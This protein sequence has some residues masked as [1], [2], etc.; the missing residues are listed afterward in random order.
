MGSAHCIGMCGGFA[1]AIGASD[2]PLRRI[3]MRQGLYSAG[4]VCTYAFLGAV[5]GFAGLYLSGVKTPLIGAQHIFS[6]LS[7]LVMLVVGLSVLSP[8]R[9]HWKWL[10]IITGWIAPIFCRLLGARGRLGFFI[11]GLANGFLPCGL[12]YAFLA[13]AV[14]SSDLLRG[15]LLMTF[16]GLGTLPAMI[17]VGC[18]GKVLSH[19]ARLR[20]YRVAACMVIIYGVV[21]ITRAFQPEEGCCAQHEAFSVIG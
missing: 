7:G 2:I 17:A 4:R 15:M 14:A 9:F 5:G 12:V 6:F 18:G 10:A 1:V 20:A 11:A 8:F 21:T 16:F 3:L 13:G 19:T